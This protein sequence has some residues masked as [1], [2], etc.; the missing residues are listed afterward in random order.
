MIYEVQKTISKKIFNSFLHVG[1]EH[2][3]FRNKHP[4]CHS[5]VFC[6][7]AFLEI[8]RNFQ[9]NSETHRDSGIGVFLC[10]VKFIPFGF[11]K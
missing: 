3:K 10:R 1:N 6:K 7:K 11:F 2:E 9:E 4:G 5:E 8:S